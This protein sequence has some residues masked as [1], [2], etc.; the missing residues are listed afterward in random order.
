MII[1]TRSSSLA[2]AQTNIVISLL[3]GE[4]IEIKK[5]NA[6][7]DKILDK[8][9]RSF[10]IGAFVRE[11]DAMIVS[12]EI[13]LAVNSLKDMPSEDAEG[14]V[15][16]AVL[17]RGPIED[18]LLSD[19]PLE[20]LPQGAVVGTSSVRRA[21]ILHNIRPDIEIRDLRGNVHTRLD[22]WKRGDYDAIILA[23]AGLERLHL[24]EKYHILDPD[25]F[26]P[27][28]GQGAIA[29]VCAENS[30]Y[31]STLSKL[32]D[33]IT[34]KDVDVER[35]ILCELG[36]GCSIPVGI[37]ATGGG[38]K[39]TAVAVSDDNIVRVSQKINDDSDIKSVAAEL[40]CGI[41]GE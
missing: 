6:S 12:G 35:K 34:R 5:I 11:L 25:V 9:L 39:V 1:G 27:A 8:P 38:S 7:G 13:D 2:M 14:T 4:D 16:A 18:V 3:D 40:R 28:A 19:L 17:P 21:A 20:E 10:G 22:K 30:P 32:N 41:C 36:S 26:I 15:L 37:H 23:R 33:D 24:E 31:F 29:V